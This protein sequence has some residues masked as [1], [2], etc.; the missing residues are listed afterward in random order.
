MKTQSLRHLPL[1]ALCL[2]G[3]VATADEHAPA[4]LSF[5]VVPQQ[6]AARLA[7]LWA[8]IFDYIGERA[9]VQIR[10]AT[11]PDIPSFEQRLAAGQY[12]LAYMNPYHYT[13]FHE[14]P[15]YNAFANQR[16]K[17]IRGIL[18]TP[19]DSDINDIQAL[20]GQ[21]LA[22]PAPAAFAASVLPRAA[23]RRV[24]IAIEPRYVRSHDSVYLA[25]AQGLYPAGGGIERTFQNTDPKVRERLRILWRTDAY[26]PHAFAAHPRLDPAL[27][28]RVRDV[29]L[30]MSDD[31][32]GRELL[33]AVGFSGIDGAGDADWDDV[34]AL[35]IDLL[36]TTTQ[37]ANGEPSNADQ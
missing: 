16:D 17:R 23:L 30:A 1:I 2:Y 6:A 26:T 27:V 3:I 7:S 24:G 8:P 25:V 15:G 29:M 21:T 34:R 11:A 31:P 9:G 33:A 32:A 35:G 36:D 37:P 19:K 4:S 10:F 22:F 14:R 13:V 18:V 28:A 5:G 12:D 20:T